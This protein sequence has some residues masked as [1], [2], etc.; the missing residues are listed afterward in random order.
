[1]TSLD[2]E[3]LEDSLTL[4]FSSDPSMEVKLGGCHRAHML[5]FVITVVLE[6][7]QSPLCLTLS[8]GAGPNGYRT[9]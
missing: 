5:V 6:V 4:L 8:I 9:V 2:N 7:S 3:P 1:M